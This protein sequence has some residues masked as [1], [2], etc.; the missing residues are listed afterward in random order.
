[1]SAREYMHLTLNEAHSKK[2]NSSIDS[3]VE[4][5]ACDDHHLIYIA[6]KKVLVI[7]ARDFVYLKRNKQI[8]ATTY[9]TV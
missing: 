6:Y 4:L 7:S 9:L 3:L 1:V 8:D 2:N 5:S